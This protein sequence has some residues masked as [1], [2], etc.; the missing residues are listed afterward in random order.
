[1]T[2]YS[3]EQQALSQVISAL[4]D[5]FNVG[6]MLFTES[7][8]GTPKGSYVRFGVRQTTSINKTALLN[9]VNSLDING[10]K[11][12]AAYDAYAMY[13]AYLY[14]AGQT[15][16]AGAVQPKRDHR[17]NPNNIYAGPLPGNALANAAASVNT[18]PLTA[19]CQKNFIIFISNGPVDSGENNGAQSVL[20]GLGGKLNSDPIPLT[21]NQ[22]QA[23]WSD[24][25][26]R[27]LSQTDVAP[28]IP[29]TQSLT[30]YTINVYDPSKARLNSVASHIAL[31]KS[32]AL[33]GGGKY[34]AAYDATS[35]SVA[36]SQIF[37]E[38]N[39]I[40]SVFASTSLPVSVNV[41]GTSLNQVYIG[42]F[43]PDANMAPRWYGN[44]KE[45]QFALD[46]NTDQ[47][48]LTDA[49]GN[50]AYSSSTGF[51]LPTATSFW[52]TPST[53]WGFRPTPDT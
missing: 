29:G 38:V 31:M 33:R 23:N 37:Q 8:S 22:E 17:N 9:L 32:M 7:G 43:R 50:P 18:A 20:T 53:F 13:E 14:F 4:N 46:P 6:L 51:I 41:R 1:N 35:I 42:V 49:A 11:G 28:S 15:A 47:L 2:A 27:F 52:T 45:Y 39:A 44:F 30:T 40:N 24:E 48:L 19:A 3:I 10:D 12:S 25:F 5:D 36:L 21:P 26:A 16:Y 34:F